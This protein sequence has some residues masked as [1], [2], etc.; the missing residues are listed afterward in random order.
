M[1][2]AKRLVFPIVLEHWLFDVVVYWNGNRDARRKSVN[3]FRFR[4]VITVQRIT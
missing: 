2:R 4:Q 1:K 3:L